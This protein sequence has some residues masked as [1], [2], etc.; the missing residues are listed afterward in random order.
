[1]KTTIG[2]QEVYLAPDELPE[3]EYS[4]IEVVDPSKVRGSRSTTFDVPGS[5]EAFQ[6][7]GGR[8]LNEEVAA[9]QPFR[10]GEGSQILFDGICTPVEWSDSKV[11]VAA[12]GDNASW[13]NAAKNTKCN[14]VDLGFTEDV[15]ADMQVAS[16]TDEDRVD[17]YP[18]IDYG[19]MNLYTATTN[20]TVDKLY[21]A[22]KV[23]KMLERFFLDNGY[24]VK[25]EG[26]LTRFWKKLIMPFAGGVPL[27]NKRC[28]LTL[29]ET[30]PFDP[31]DPGALEFVTSGYWLG[32]LPFRTV[33]TDACSQA[34]GLPFGGGVPWG[35]RASQAGEWEAYLEA[36]FEVR[37]TPD[38]LNRGQSLVFKLWDNT[39]DEILST[40]RK[41]IPFGTLATTVNISEVVA[42]ATLAVNQEVALLVGMEPADGT[43]QPELY[44]RIPRRLIY[45]GKDN[46]RT[47]QLSNTIGSNLSV[48]DVI[49]SLSNIFRLAIQTNQ[50]TNTVTFSTLDDYLRPINA[51]IDWSERVD[52]AKE[53]VKVQPEVPVRYRLAYT[54]DDKDEAAQNYNGQSQWTAEGVFEAGGRDSE[55]EIG[56]KFAATQQ[57]L[58]FFN[59][60]GIADSSA[61]LI[62]VIKEEDKTTDYVKCKPRILIYDGLADGIWRFNGVDRTQYPRAY[63]A[64]D[65]GTDVNL[66]FG[67]DNG[68]PGTVARYWRNYLTRSVKPYLKA[69]VVVYDDEFMDFAFGRPRL[70]HDG[71][72]RSWV[73][74]QKIKGKRFGDN[75]PVEC[76]L[77]PL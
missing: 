71:I 45:R 70:V 55:A 34:F 29:T 42:T 50:L 7:L 47:A 56:V 31:F 11:T 67:D 77:I 59:N 75:E 30:E 62:P 1:M 5:I 73:Y 12:F 51:G 64:G 52:E 44:V 37:R 49:S 66:G 68:R 9:E 28:S 19:S 48:G 20:V 41:P 8:A 26:S 63:F 23:H 6:V 32:L 54:A 4:L 35:L 16:W 17:V 2:D 40:F 10:I 46:N 58:R 72:M 76:E 22:I 18:L 65:G 36:S 25:V 38:T 24:T 39:T 53:V 43:T 15:D 21:P 69:Q 3:F 13:I 27:Q 60:L 14:E 74:V 33:E 61:L 57:G